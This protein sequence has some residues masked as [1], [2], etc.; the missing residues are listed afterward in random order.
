MC[1][2]SCVSHPIVLGVDWTRTVYW[3][4]TSS[5]LESVWLRGHRVRFVHPCAD[6]VTV[7]GHFEW[8]LCYSRR[9]HKSHGSFSGRTRALKATAGP[10][11]YLMLYFIMFDFLR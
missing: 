6:H 1:V 3:P 2:L 5:I 11:S 10:S 4:K 7:H 9:W 8:K